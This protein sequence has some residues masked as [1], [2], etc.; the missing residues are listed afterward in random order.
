MNDSRQTFDF[1]D[2]E[3]DAVGNSGRRGKR[4]Q[5]HT[6]TTTVVT[7]DDDQ[8]QIKLQEIDP[9]VLSEQKVKRIQECFSELLCYSNRKSLNFFVHEHK[10]YKE[11]FEINFLPK[12]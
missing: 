1:H 7:H 11:F 5:K 3:E 9:E 12:E 6:K 8:D 4:R 10:S 2:G